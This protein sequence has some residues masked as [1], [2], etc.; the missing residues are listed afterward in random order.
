MPRASDVPSMRWIT[1][2]VPLPRNKKPA[3]GEKAGRGRAIGRRLRG[4][5]AVIDGAAFA[6]KTDI[7]HIDMAAPPRPIRVC[8]DEP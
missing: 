2:C 7:T 4:Q 6:G 3:C 1:S 5:S 8:R